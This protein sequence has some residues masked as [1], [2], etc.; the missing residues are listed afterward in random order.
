MTVASPTATIIARTLAL[1]AVA[2]LAVGCAEGE[3]RLP[4]PDFDPRAPIPELGDSPGDDRQTS[5][6]GS[7]KFEKAIQ[8]NLESKPKG[9]EEEKKPVSRQVVPIAGAFAGE[10]PVQFEDWSWSRTDSATVVTYSKKGDSPDAIIYAESFSELGRTFPSLDIARFLYT[11][12]P[13]YGQSAT[14]PQLTGGGLG[15]AASEFELSPNKVVSTILRGSSST[16][17]LGLNYQSRRGT[18]SGWRW[19]GR[20]GHGVDLRFAR[21]RGRFGTSTS[22]DRSRAMARFRQMSRK[23]PEMKHASESLGRIGAS[24]QAEG[25]TGVGGDANRADAARGTPSAGWMLIGQVTERRRTPVHLA[26]GCRSPCPVAGELAHFLGSL[27]P[28]AEVRGRL[29][30]P[31][32]PDFRA[33]ADKRGLPL[34]DRDELP[35]LTE[36]IRSLRR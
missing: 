8:E 18:F 24:E 9:S 15:N 14:I 17:G 29:A 31:S 12:D 16:L 11:V 32:E 13:S 34:V 33:F 28:Q 4:Y 1:A 25:P 5:S 7:S 2:L 35:S 27:R 19:V 26:V 22:G 30:T 10:I 3:R 20:N 23:M 6:E 21:T 36:S